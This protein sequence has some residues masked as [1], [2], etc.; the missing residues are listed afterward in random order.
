MVGMT[1]STLGL[2]VDE[3]R[4]CF[5]H[6]CNV[7]TGLGPVVPRVST[8]FTDFARTGRVYDLSIVFHVF[9]EFHPF[10]QAFQKEVHLCSEHV[11]LLDS[12]YALG[13]GLET[14]FAPPLVGDRLLD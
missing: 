14:L 6:E 2:L 12:V 3:T 7:F 4:C 9:L 5:V 10:V 8:I 13:T 11:C 1:S